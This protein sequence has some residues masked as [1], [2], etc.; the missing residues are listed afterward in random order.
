MR[1]LARLM[2]KRGVVPRTRRP[3]QPQTGEV[4]GPEPQTAKPSNSAPDHQL[5]RMPSR[6]LINAFQEVPREEVKDPKSVFVVPD[7][8]STPASVAKGVKEEAEKPDLRRG[9]KQKAPTK[10]RGT[11]M[12][13]C[14][15]EEEAFLLR[16]YASDSGLGFS[17]WARAALFQAMKKPVPKRE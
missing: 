15:S 2:M 10:R 5:G 4:V 6:R 7:A 9:P 11:S 13:L 3:Q 1:D 14:V 17:E 8:W 12:S 16:K